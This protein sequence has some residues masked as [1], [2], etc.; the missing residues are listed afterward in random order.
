[1][2][3]L[4]IVGSDD[5]TWGT[6]LNEFLSVE[7]NADGTLDTGG[8]LGNYAP[9]ASPTFTGT[10]TVP[11][12]SN[13]TDAVTKQYVDDLDDDN[14]KLTGNQT[15]AGDKTF[16]GTTFGD[17][18]ADGMIG[19]DGVTGVGGAITVYRD[20]SDDLDKPRIALSATGG[21]LLGDGSATPDAAISR[22]GA[23]NISFNAA[24]LSDLTDPTTAQDAATKNYVD[25]EMAQ[26]E[27]TG[28]VGYRTKNLNGWFAALSGARTTPADI[29]VIGDSISTSSYTNGAWPW[30]LANMLSVRG[31]TAKHPTSHFVFA[32]TT[33]F[34][35]A[36]DTCQGTATASGIG[37]WSSSM[38]N[39]QTASHTATIDGFSVVYTRHSNGGSIQVRDGGAGGT[40]LT[41]IDTT[42]THKGSQIWTSGALANTS[43]QIH[44]TMVCDPGETVLFEGLYLHFGTRARGVRVWPAGHPGYDSGDFTGQADLALDL[45]ENIQP[46]LVIIATGTNDASGG[47]PEVGYNTAI[48]G[49]IT[50]I[51]AVATSDIAL[52]IPYIND[53]FTEAEAAMGRSIAE[54]LDIGLID[55]SVGAGDWSTNGDPAHVYSY[56]NIH[57]D[58]A[59]NA[60]IA[61]H[62]HA[63]LTGDPL[64]GLAHAIGVTKLAQEEPTKTWQQGAG[65][66]EIG[67]FFGSPTL[68]IYDANANASATLYN[69]SAGTFLNTGGAALV[70]GNGTSVAD[71]YLN[72]A[73]PAQLAVNKGEGTLSA[74]LSPVINAQTG[75]SHTLALTDAGKQITRSNAGASTQTFPQNSDAAIPIGTQIRILNI[76]AGTV[77]LQAGTGA[78]LTGDTSLMTNKT[79][80]V[81][82]I[83][84]NGWLSG[85]LGSGS[86]THSGADI[87][88]GTVAPARL[89][90]GTTSADTI[91]TGASTFIRRPKI[92]MND[93]GGSAF[94]NTT[95]ETTIL[96][97]NPSFVANAL[98]VNDVLESE[99][100]GTFLNN[101]GA[102]QTVNF[103]VKFGGTTL[104]NW[105]SN[106][107]ASSA[108]GPNYFFRV[109]MTFYG[110][111]SARATYS[112][113][114]S[115]GLN[116]ISSG[117]ANGTSTGTIP[118]ITS[119]TS[120]LEVTA[121]MSTGT[122]TSTVTPRATFIKYTPAG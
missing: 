25:L 10:V 89:G 91:L 1:M 7:H 56:D 53:Q 43:R 18:G 122:A 117:M 12:P 16:T 34:V 75:T 72:R 58:S 118:D 67:S 26:S 2:P 63:I 13:S 69:H 73:G 113:G 90:S 28:S 3:R 46:A 31:G 96:S 119:S 120:S 8:T 99:F 82:K 36:M 52:W 77:T 44:L 35:R 109:I 86:H 48:R 54:D 9:L 19:F 101:S 94:S 14:V 11:A 4:P 29:V 39:G 23:G 50:A 55:A 111:T 102:N 27:L 68:S 6:L 76:G 57:P 121:T 60:V 85:V 70:L 107:L 30:Q 88:S 62:A 110:A 20:S 22:A 51:E 81:T 106:G 21:L 64:G 66:L 33:T 95:T 100:Q 49:L 41:T 42:G 80:L 78:T 15:I 32:K 83:S 93:T 74:N 112:L 105:T 37:G 79:A 84:T 5:G 108:F 47:S 59:G 87:T 114:L 103:K 24:R 116:L 61:H 92:L 40:L 17:Y 38:T 45:I 65:K 115:N 104:L 97:S 98:A 71:V